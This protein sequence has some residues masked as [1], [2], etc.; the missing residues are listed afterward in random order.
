MSVVP[1]CSL[2]G[3]PSHKDHVHEPGLVFILSNAAKS[4]LANNLTETSQGSGCRV[5]VVS[6]RQPE[7]W[8]QGS[9]CLC[10]YF[11]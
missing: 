10:G 3:G 6:K 4:E 5:L 1:S 11:N 2:H 9:V 7:V 8:M